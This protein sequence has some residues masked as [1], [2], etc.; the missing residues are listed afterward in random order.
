MTL[1]IA[2]DLGGTQIRGALVDAEG[3][4]LNRLATATKA[5]AGPTVVIQQLVDA[6]NEVSRDVDP[7]TYHWRG[8]QLTWSIGH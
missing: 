2:I 3:N 5:M 4:I 7:A 1:A 6:A 8:R